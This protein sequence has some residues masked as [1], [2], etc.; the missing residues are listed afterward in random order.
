LFLFR[1]RKNRALLTKKLPR[2]KLKRKRVVKKGL[3]MKKLVKE[4]RKRKN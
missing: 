4:K 3:R 1:K 2:G